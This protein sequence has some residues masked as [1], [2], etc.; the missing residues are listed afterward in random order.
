MV[1]GG[2]ILSPA[3]LDAGFLAKVA[4]GLMAWSK[5]RQLFVVVGGG[6][7]ARR[8]IE[9]AR[10]C[11]VSE[12]LLDRIG[13]QATRLNAQ[14]L[15]CILRK[16]GANVNL[17]IP[18]T[19]AQALRLATQHDLVVMGG[20]V[21]GHSTDY[22]AVELAVEGKCDR[23]VNA[24]NVDGVYTRD[25]NKHRD[26]KFQPSLSFE[27]LLGIIEEREWSTAGAPG[28]M[29]GPATVML[30]RNA[31]PTCVARGTDLDNLAKAVA[32]KPFHGSKIEG[33]KVMV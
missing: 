11:K 12:D 31:V 27:D 20:T 29:D 24:T 13:I 23:F 6:H 10:A 26:A 5:E 30:A 15:A 4:E 25:P 21:P 8:H 2:S 16:F 28:V 9:A 19:T 32:G 3:E 33:A 14:T 7:P 18:H 1:F 22:V 17:E